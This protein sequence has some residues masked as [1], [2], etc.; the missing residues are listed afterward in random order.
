MAKECCEKYKKT[1]KYCKGCPLIKKD[2]DKK[3]KN[4]KEDRKKDRKAKKKK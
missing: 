4:R 1:G 2:K 3:K